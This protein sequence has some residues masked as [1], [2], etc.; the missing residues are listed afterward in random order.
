MANR[1]KSQLLTTKEA[2]EFLRLKPHTLENMRSDGKGPIFMKLG[3]RVFY[4]RADLKT[5]LDLWPSRRPRPGLLPGAAVGADQ[6]SGKRGRGCCR[7]IRLIS[8]SRRQ[9]RMRGIRPFNLIRA[10]APWRSCHLRWRCID[11]EDYSAHLGGAL[12]CD[13]GVRPNP[14][15]RRCRPRLVLPRESLAT[16]LR[17]ARASSVTSRKTGAEDR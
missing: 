13:L 7:A 3:G 17:A 8:Q 6:R 16:S 5:W 15:R 11:H 1:R 4:H 12:S 9:S 2:A 10:A 14:A